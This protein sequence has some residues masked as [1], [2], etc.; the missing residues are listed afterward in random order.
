[1]KLY[2][3]KDTFY[4]KVYGDRTWWIRFKW[5]LDKKYP[6]IDYEIVNLHYEVNI[7]DLQIGNDDYC[8]CSFAHYEEDFELSKI[9]LS[10]SIVHRS[11]SNSVEILILLKGAA[12]FTQNNETMSLEKGQAILVKADTAYK[13][14]TNSEVE[15]Y[16]AGV[17]K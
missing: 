8:I 4:D 12:T 3:H 16:K 13:V 11:I 14:Q 17:P 9:E 15:I 5:L 10:K 2:I 7:N 1:M 6:D